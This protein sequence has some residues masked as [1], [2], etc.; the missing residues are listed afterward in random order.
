MVSPLEQFNFQEQIN[1]L[2]EIGIALSSELNLDVLLEK[3]LR[4]ARALTTADAGTLYLLSDGAL[5]FK[6]MQNESLD[7]FM[8]GRGQPPVNLD[9]VALD[10]TN[11]SAYAALLG[12]TVCIDNVYESEAFDFSGPRR[13]DTM[14]G[15]R[16][17]SMLV[18]PM[19]D[20]HGEI[21]GV[22]QLLNATDRDSH[23]VVGFDGASVNLTEALA[24]QVAVAVTN[25]SLIKETKD[26]FESLIQVL[27]TAVDCKSS[28]T[29]NHIQRVADFNLVLA[30]AISKKT[31]GPF[32]DISFSSSELEEIRIAGWLHDVGKVITPVR[33]MDK[34]TKL[35]AT[36][37]RIQI[38]EL[39]FAHLKHIVENNALK[40]KIEVLQS[41][42][43]AEELAL[44]DA[45]MI[46]KIEGLNDEYAFLYQCNLP[47]EFMSD[48]KL[49][50]LEEIA[51]KTYFED[52]EEKPYLTEDEIHNLSIRRGSLTE[53][54]MTI[55]Q[56]HVLMTGEMLAQVP[57]S[58]HLKNVPLYAAQHHEKLNGLGYPL[59]LKADDIPLQSRILAVADFYEALSAKDRPYKKPLPEKVILSILQDAADRGEIDVDVVNLI[60][61]DNIHQTFEE[62]DKAPKHK[63]RIPF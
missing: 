21:I 18:V 42:A 39:R 38:L 63:Q 47:K 15:Y 12:K 29:G 2:T 33:V 9:P 24:S 34:A 32:K 14:T 48:E 5:H 37:D 61:K 13:Y 59:H 30:D 10:N 56:S 40:R 51:K 27:A 35:E 3:A 53:E 8:G 25:A 58:R 49:E 28:Y 4:Y 20:H 62:I 1:R 43:D 45:E 16:S 44:I 7:V 41:G 54:Q 6:I 57:F 11:V 60:L 23:E 52:G 22:L 50:R 55:M 17:R 26:L 19:K 46:Q 36:V 31:D